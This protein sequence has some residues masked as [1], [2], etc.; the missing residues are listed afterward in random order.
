MPLEKGN[1]PATIGHNVKTEE[2]AGKSRSQ[3]V[4]IALHTAND[5]NYAVPT[6]ALT[7]AQINANNRNSWATNL[8]VNDCKR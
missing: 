2:A 3:A 8:T 1:N 5:D 7:T 4:A 6:T